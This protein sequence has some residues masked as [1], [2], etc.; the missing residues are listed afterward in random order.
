MR[1]LIFPCEYEFHSNYKELGLEYP[2]TLTDQDTIDFL[3]KECYIINGPNSSRSSKYLICK[4][5]FKRSESGS[6]YFS[7]HAIDKNGKDCGWCG[8]DSYFPRYTWNDFLEFLGLVIIDRNKLSA[9]VFDN[10]NEAKQCLDDFLEFRQV[11]WHKQ[12]LDYIN[13]DEVLEEYDTRLNDIVN[14]LNNLTDKREYIDTIRQ[15]YAILNKAK[16]I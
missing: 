16:L 7:G 14:C 1:K 6:V 8:C 11:K 9:L 5:H 12:W 15:I 2:Y 10:Y 3:G 13:S 4:G